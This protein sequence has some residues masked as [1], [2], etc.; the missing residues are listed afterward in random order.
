M[1]AV[2]QKT[3]ELGP[4]TEKEQ[5]ELELGIPKIL[6]TEFNFLKF[7]FFDLA[8]DSQREKIKIEEWIETGEGKFHILWL[9]TRSIEGRFP[10]DFEKRLHRAIEQV[11]NVSPKPITNPLRLG[12]IRYIASIMGIHPDSGKNYEDIQRAFKNIV[13]TSIEAKGTFQLK[14]NS[15]TKRTIDDTFHLY[16][17]VIFRGEELPN[18]K[19]ADAVFLM[20]GSWYLQ[21]INRNY[22]VPLDWRFYNQLTGNITT[23]MYE[24]LSIY[25]YTALERNQN[26]HEA[27][28]SQIC[29][30]F[31][32]TRQYPGWK[33]RKQLKHAH[34]S[35]TS[36]G[37]FTK[38]EWLEIT[39]PADWLLRYWIGPKA[40]DEYKHNKKE[41]RR[42]GVISGRPVPI[43][44]RRRHKRR[45]EGPQNAADNH[46]I[47]K[48]FVSRGLTPKVA[49][50]L[51]E[52]H[53]EAFIA[54][55]LEVFDW[56]VETKSHLIKYN[57]AGF[58]RT[59]VEGEYTDPPGFISKEERQHRVI[60]AEEFKKQQE[61]WELVEQYRFELQAK[62]EQKVYGELILWVRDYKK[63]NNNRHPTPQEK[64]VK[65]EK[66]IKGLPS[67]EERQKQIFGEVVFK[68]KTPEAFEEEL[69]GP[70]KKQI[71]KAGENVN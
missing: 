22:V 66:L 56:L 27:R 43:P 8:K 60:K 47:A 52:S 4:F 19:N 36:F 16:D 37:Y 7:P 18:G 58:L 62:P 23:R 69:K 6:R 24:Y 12:S 55:K 3:T 11:I 13:K 9:V 21:N 1:G 14:E 57:P 44:G 2:E 48:E 50:Q 71:T 38:V 5:L 33:A 41:I 61:W 26:Y 64:K 59:S 20:L 65:R 54:H 45:N 42:H 10:G 46:E 28:Y 67:L 63:Q 35:L 49:E 39:D 32:L 51:A 15:K 25:F 29:N 30:Y 53:P 68:A 31:P 34:E 40:Q 70:R 17:R